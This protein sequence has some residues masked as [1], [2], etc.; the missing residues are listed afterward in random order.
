MSMVFRTC[1]YYLKIV[2][3]CRAAITD[4]TNDQNVS[5]AIRTH[6]CHFNVVNQSSTVTV[7]L[8]T[9]LRLMSGTVIWSHL[10]P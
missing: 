5:T 9:T 10:S 3:Q 6:I 4:L 8:W 7:D 2:K 1:I